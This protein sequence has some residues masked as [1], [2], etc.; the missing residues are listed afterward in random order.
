MAK[1][2]Q[3][4]RETQR[5]RKVKVV[6]GELSIPLLLQF[7]AWLVKL[8]FASVSLPSGFL[9]IEEDSWGSSLLRHYKAE[10]VVA[11]IIGSSITPE[12]RNHFY[13]TL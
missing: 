9:I 8:Q 3:S 7:P 10:N 12:S 2:S 6:S 1:M 5:Q 4:G 11:A 13:T